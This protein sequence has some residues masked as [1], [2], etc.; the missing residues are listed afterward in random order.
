MITEIV[1][2]DLPAKMSREEAIAKYRL[3]IPGWV[4]NP[5]LI[6]KTFLFDEKTRRGGGVYNWKS[7]EAAKL[8][9]GPEFQKRIQATF[10]SQPQFQYFE[11]PIVIDNTTKEVIDVAA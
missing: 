11:T 8:G 10:G 6:R 7:I 4:A 9:H 1:L 3:S 2:F 5:D